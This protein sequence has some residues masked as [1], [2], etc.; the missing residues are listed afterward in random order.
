[1]PL[2]RATKDYNHALVTRSKLHDTTRTVLYEHYSDGE[3][4]DRLQVEYHQKG[5]VR[6]QS[7]LTQLLLPEEHEEPNRHRQVHQQRHPE[8]GFPESGHGAR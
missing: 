7:G 3:S 5:G 2:E 8:P 4:N 1:M 6:P